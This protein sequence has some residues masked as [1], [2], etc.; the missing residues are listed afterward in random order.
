MIFF[1]NGQWHL[2]QFQQAYK[3]NIFFRMPRV[4]NEL[5]VNKQ[6][7]KNYSCLYNSMNTDFISLVLWY[8]IWAYTLDFT[9]FNAEFIKIEDRLCFNEIGIIFNITIINFQGLTSL[10]TKWIGDL[11]MRVVVAHNFGY[12]PCKAIFPII[13]FLKGQAFLEI[14][15]NNVH[16]EIIWQFRSHC[17]SLRSYCLWVMHG[18]IPFQI[19][20]SH[21]ARRSKS[22]CLQNY[23]N[24]CNGTQNSKIQRMIPHS[25][26]L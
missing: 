2:A 4:L 22:T 18:N 8:L 1:C 25:L 5:I 24:S 11:P 16:L 20:T 15:R 3:H 6:L 26:D 14:P 13:T 19:T 12:K 9:V 10:S 23:G 7:K 17:V 21:H